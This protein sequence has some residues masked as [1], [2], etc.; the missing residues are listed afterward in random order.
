[1][2]ET[3]EKKYEKIEE[4]KKETKK[5]E[6]EEKKK[7]TTSPH[8]WHWAEFA[9][10]GLAITGFVFFLAD[11]AG[12]FEV[13][14]MI[15][16]VLLCGTSALGCALVWNLISIKR[17]AAATALL[18]RDVAH[19]A[20]LNEAQG[21][22]QARK[23]AQDEEMKKKLAD[24][25]KAQMLLG[26]SVNTLDDVK[27]QEEDMMAE[28]MELLEK[29]RALVTE[30]QKDMADLN[31]LALEAAKIELRDRCNMYFA[32]SDKDG[33]G[34]DVGSSEWHV[35]AD[36]LVDNGIPIDE[37]AAGEDGNLTEDEFND[38]LDKTLDAHFLTLREA[39]LDCI[40]IE[41]EIKSIKIDRI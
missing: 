34:M 40:K 35:L 28:R 2:A 39:V 32:K 26:A 18:E 23:K 10:I 24:M 1:M 3:E 31:E 16:A 25:E 33:D 41:D 38:W 5:N 11:S 6:K 15:A 37:S 14:Q 12:L 27:K 17:L 8:I 19:F 7:P 4:G 13:P 20:E 29:R 22:M 36:L 30:M 21:E 9:F